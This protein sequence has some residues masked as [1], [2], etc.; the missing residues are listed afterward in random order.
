MTGIDP[1]D[2]GAA[3]FFIFIGATGSRVKEKQKKTQKT[4]YAEETAAGYGCTRAPDIEA[5]H[6]PSRP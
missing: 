2:R 5:M 1:I 3:A 4:R 6:V